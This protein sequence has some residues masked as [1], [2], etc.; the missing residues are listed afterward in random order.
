MLKTIKVVKII[1][2]LVKTLYKTVSI[3]S[4]HA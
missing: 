2:K 3:F 4:S 1:K